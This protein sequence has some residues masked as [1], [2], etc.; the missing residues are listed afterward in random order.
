MDPVRWVE[1]VMAPSV[2]VG[3]SSTVQVEAGSE[4]G[5]LTIRLGGGALMAVQD[6][7]GAILAARVL[8][9]LGEGGG[10]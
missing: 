1:A 9:H 10:C 6:E 7:R 5:G 4:G 2:A 3:P 8:K